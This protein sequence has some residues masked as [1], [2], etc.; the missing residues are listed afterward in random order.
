MKI[1]VNTRW[2]LQNKLEGIGNFSHNLLSRLVKNQ[3]EVEFDFYFD[4]PFH[5]SFL[6]GKNVNGIRLMPPARHPYLWYIWYEYSLKRK[7]NQTKPDLFFS[8]DGFIPTTGKTKTLNTIHDLNFE[9]NPDWVPS[10]VAKYYKKF[11]PLCTKVATRL[12][13]VSE[14]SK[15]DVENT[16]GIADD[17]ID[18]VYNSAS[19]TFIKKS[20]DE[21]SNF[22][23]QYTQGQPYFIFLGA[24]NPRKNLQ[25]IFPAFDKL[26]SDHK[27]VVVGEKMHWDLEIEQAYKNMANQDAV[28]FT[29]R[30]A[31]ADLNTALSGAT[32]LVF[33][34]L[35][36]GFG[37]P[38]IEAFRAETAVITANN[39]SMP[40]VA[41]DAAILVN[42]ESQD[43]ITLAMQKLESEPELRKSLIKKGKV[44][45]E[46][47][48][49]DASAKK[50][51]DIMLKTINS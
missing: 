23:A 9:H 12:I 11:F 36:E 47:F 34:S 45:A 10:N 19:S 46:K 28:V 14:F 35:F 1:A 17:K 6:Y 42:A 33:P 27:L 32:A 29:G 26:N 4:R 31:S 43:E 25:N 48:D 38:I 20:D 3:P 22:K 39:S 50:L 44:Q 13:T 18:V 41:G 16:Y 8:P 2:L 40:E 24:L 21:I 7:L 51:W 30:L 49:W 15:K 5:A 37:I